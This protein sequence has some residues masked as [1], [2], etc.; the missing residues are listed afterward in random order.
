MNSF[1]LLFS[2]VGG[3]GVPGGKGEG[4]DV[5][6]IRDS[7]DFSL[8]YEICQMRKFWGQYWSYVISIQKD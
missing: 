3:G 2:F 1:Y 5:Y 8:Q 4:T 6:I 7:V